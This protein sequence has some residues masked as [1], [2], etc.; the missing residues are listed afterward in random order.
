MK[1]DPAFVS[2]RDEAFRD[3]REVVGVRGLV[4]VDVLD[5]GAVAEARNP[6]FNA[7]V[8]SGCMI[9]LIVK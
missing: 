4:R 9:R 1:V 2:E 5:G 6:S 8:V 3:F 7:I